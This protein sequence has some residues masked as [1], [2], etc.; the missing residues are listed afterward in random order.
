M[1]NIILSLLFVLSSATQAQDWFDKTCDNIDGSVTQEDFKISDERNILK[2]IVNQAGDLEIN[3]VEK[4]NMNEIGFKEFV[5]DF[6]TNPNN[7]RVNADK[8]EKVIFLLKSLQKDTEKIDSLRAYVYDVYLYLWDLESEDKYKSTYVNLNC[9]KREK[10][11]N[12]FPLKIIDDLE[13]K[14]KTKGSDLRRGIGVPVFGGDT[15]KKN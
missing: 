1:K 12:S 14:P 3:G 15:V 9:K 2:I 10:I 5:L 11:F 8:P 13:N 4:S 7:K 6:V